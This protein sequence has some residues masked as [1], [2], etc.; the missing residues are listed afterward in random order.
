MS[1]RP[2]KMTIFVPPVGQH[3]VK[4]SIFLKVTRSGIFEFPDHLWLLRNENLMLKVG[5]RP[6]KDEI[7]DIFKNRDFGPKPFW[8][9]DF[10]PSNCKIFS[11]DA[12]APQVLRTAQPTSPG[13]ATHF[14]WG[15]S[16]S[17]EKILEFEGAKSSF[18]KGLGSKSRFLEKSKISFF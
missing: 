7:F 8:N 2:E 17:A 4:K 12:E 10:A 16:A 18:Q 3:G 9:D 13:C 6:Q 15:A 1:L 5:F 14:W 11:A